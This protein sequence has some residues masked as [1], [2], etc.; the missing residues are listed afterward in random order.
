MEQ[1]DRL[2]T[3]RKGF[4]SHVTRLYNKVDELIYKEVDDYSVALLI[5]AMEQL[6]SKG[7]KLNKID[8]QIAT[9]ID[10][11][12]EL[13][14]YVLETEELQDDITDKIAKI[15]TFIELQRPKSKESSSHL[16]NQ[17]PVSLHE[18]SMNPPQ[19]V[20]ATTLSNS[21][22][23][24]STS[25]LQLDSTTTT[26]TTLQP[27]APIPFVSTPEII[28]ENLE[29]PPLIPAASYM[30]V[31]SLTT[32]QRPVTLSVPDVRSLHNTSSVNHF[33]LQEPLPGTLA[34]AGSYHG[35]WGPT[36]CH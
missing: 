13:E 11:P 1:L 8:E 35:S 19:L 4:K 23:Q 2:Q 16:A 36:V 33:A 24:V 18:V 21:L 30:A 32:Q 26:T 3:S 12:H 15:Q 5:K 10:D 28:T 34:S 6:K 27:S 9:L 17:P 7:D 25:S 14:E 22:P 29:L 31:S 20:T